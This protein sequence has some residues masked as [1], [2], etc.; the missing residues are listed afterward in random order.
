MPARLFGIDFGGTAIK[1]GAITS[2]GRVLAEKSVPN[3]LEAGPAEAFERMADLWREL[4]DG[5][6]I[7]IGI[8]GLIDT[9]RG[10][11]GASPNLP[12]MAGAHLRLELARRTG[13]SPSAIQVENDANAAALGEAW[14]GAARG[15]RHA[16]VVTLGT[17]IGGGLILD[18]RPYSG[19]GQGGEIGHVVVDPLGPPC[20]CGSRGCL[21]TL[22]SASAA[23]RRAL[24]RGLPHGDPGNLELCVERAR[25]RAGPERALLLEIGRDLGRG[26]GPVVCLLDV[27][28]FVFSGGFSAAF[29]V[30]E[31]A[32]RAG[33]AE[34][35]F[36]D[37]VAAVR[38]RQAVLG[39]SAGWIGAA[40]LCAAPARGA[41]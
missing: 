39:P 28:L 11:V 3:G 4:G 38:L 18:G 15:E 8:A 5:A 20:A 13:L 37:R 6:P 21:E 31:P 9:R 24:E 26:L 33:I 1:A 17:G 22:A 40:R 34:R 14:L 27:R 12:G 41:E 7:G 35:S 30:L 10:V 16:L 2:E 36:G 25:A 19:E 32:I 29:D 23:R